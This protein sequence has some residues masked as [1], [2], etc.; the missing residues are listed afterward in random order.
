MVA[1]MLVF[2]IDGAYGFIAVDD[3]RVI[4]LILFF[5]LAQHDL[6]L[7]RSQRWSTIVDVAACE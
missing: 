2:L 4:F 5:L 3:I 1:N 6:L 7:L